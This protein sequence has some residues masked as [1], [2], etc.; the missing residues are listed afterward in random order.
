MSKARFA[1]S[2]TNNGGDNVSEL[3]YLVA[4]EAWDDA[5]DCLTKRVAP[6]LVVD[7]NYESLLDMCA[8]FS[9]GND[10]AKRVSSWYTGGAVF[11]SFSKLMSGATPKDDIL[12]IAELRKRLTNQ[13]YKTASDSRSKERGIKLGQLN[14]H[15]LEEHVCLKEMANALARLSFAG[16]DVGTSREILEMPITE[17]VRLEILTREGI[18]SNIE[19]NNAVRK[20]AAPSTRRNPSRGLS[21]R[22]TS[23]PQ[24]KDVDAM[25]EDGGSNA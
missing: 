18:S 8:L 14:L 11:E 2:E 16:A 24:N 1:A 5:H 12:E 4:A 15:E 10:P 9:A 25:D 23:T 20:K 21:S 6:G 13:G 22:N 3:R 19:E 7:Q 17:D